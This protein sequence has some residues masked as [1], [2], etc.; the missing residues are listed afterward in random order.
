MRSGLDIG[1]PARSCVVFI[2]SSRQS[3]IISIWYRCQMSS[4]SSSDAIDF[5]DAIEPITNLV[6]DYGMCAPSIATAKIKGDLSSF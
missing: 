5:V 6:I 3:G 2:W 4:D 1:E